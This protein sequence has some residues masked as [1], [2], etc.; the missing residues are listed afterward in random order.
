LK[1]LTRLLRIGLDNV[2]EGMI[3]GSDDGE[4]VRINN[5]L[6][7]IQEICNTSIWGSEERP[8]RWT[9]P[10][11]PVS[12]K[13]TTICLDNVRT[14]KVVNSLESLIDVCVPEGDGCD[15]WKATIELY[16]ES[17]LLLLSRED[18]TDK[19]IFDYQWKVDQFAQGWFKINKGD[20]GVTNYIHDLHAGHI[21]DYLMQWRNLYTHSQQGWEAMNFAIKRYWFR[22]TNRGGGRGCGNRLQPLARWVQRRFVWM[23]GFQYEQILATVKN[24]LEVDYDNIEGMDII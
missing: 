4:N 21:S 14:R 1:I 18:L 22:C 17:L 19:Q 5:Y 8:V 23:M 6:E 12:K 16:R 20:E 13:I 3:H 9:C 11:D 7:E 2:K 10:Y 24:G 15:L